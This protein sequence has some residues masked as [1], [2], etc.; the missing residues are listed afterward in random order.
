MTY[1]PDG[2]PTGKEFGWSLLGDMPD[3]LKPDPLADFL[4]MQQEVDAL[5]EEDEITN[6]TPIERLMQGVLEEEAE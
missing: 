1:L 3:N 5:F 6:L 2:V 4:R